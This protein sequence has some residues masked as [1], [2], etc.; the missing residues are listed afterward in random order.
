ELIQLAWN[1]GL[2]R[3][4]VISEGTDAA[5]LLLAGERNQIATLFWPV[6]RPL[7]AVARWSENPRP[8]AG[9]S[10]T[11]RPF[12]SAV[13]P[14]CV[15]G[16]LVTRVLFASHISEGRALLALVGIIVASIIVIGLMFQVL[17]G[18]SLRRQAAR[19]DEA[20]ALAIVLEQLRLGMTVNA[21]LVPR[22]VVWIRR[23]LG[24]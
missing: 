16:Y 14:G 6:P 9:I 10:E 21:A 20:S 22:A 12:A 15:V 8:V 24:S 17:I 5:M 11:M 13:L 4:M 2:D 1:A 7:E 3:K 23:A 18:A 19:L